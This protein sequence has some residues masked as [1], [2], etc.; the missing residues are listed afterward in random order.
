VE[1]ANDDP[2]SIPL[3]LLPEPAPPETFGILDQAVTNAG[4]HYN[5]E[6]T[7]IGG[8]NDLVLPKAY[9]C[10]DSTDHQ[11]DD[12]PVRICGCCYPH[13]AHLA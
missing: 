8:L 12:I 9:Y 5:N 7:E 6:V 4:N 11:K 13:P 10:F 1:D 3:E 2:L